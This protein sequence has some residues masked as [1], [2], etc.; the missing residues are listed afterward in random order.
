M[1]LDDASLHIWNR[2]RC[3]VLKEI[4]VVRACNI[5][6][7]R[8]YWMMQEIFDCIELICECLLAAN[9]HWFLMHLKII[10]SIQ[11]LRLPLNRMQNY[12]QWNYW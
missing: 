10:C 5:K 4:G 8:N 11:S 7:E 6:Y 3:F 1:L 2:I 9:G 12:Y